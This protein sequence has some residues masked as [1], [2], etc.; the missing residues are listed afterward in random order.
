MAPGGLEELS[1]VLPR[2]HYQLVRVLLNDPVT[3]S[4]LAEKGS[5]LGRDVD[6]KPAV[7]TN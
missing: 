3:P 6:Q 2:I 5:R 1:S 7:V 4:L